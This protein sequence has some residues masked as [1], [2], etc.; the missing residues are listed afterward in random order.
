MICQRVIFPS[1]SYQ[2]T[3][4]QWPSSQQISNPVAHWWWTKKENGQDPGRDGCRGG[5]KQGN[6]AMMDFCERL[7]D[8]NSTFSD[9][10][11]FT[12]STG[13]WGRANTPPDWLCDLSLSHR[14]SL[15]LGWETAFFRD[16]DKS[17]EHVPV[18]LKCDHTLYSFSPQIDKDV[19]TQCF[20]IIKKSCFI[21][22]FWWVQREAIRK[23]SK[24]VSSLTTCL[25][26]LTVS[27]F[28]F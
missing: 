16:L 9:G 2:H 5:N 8:K 10:K 26:S 17:S 1:W 14:I 21:F 11:W 27:T 4:N 19:L 20:S 7:T 12:I 18:C 3:L 22:S 24:K 13:T 15:H 6:P 23:G 28:F 25:N